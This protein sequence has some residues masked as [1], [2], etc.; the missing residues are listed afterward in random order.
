ME[1]THPPHEYILTDDKFYRV[2]LLKKKFDEV[3]T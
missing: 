3:I 2:A 1:H